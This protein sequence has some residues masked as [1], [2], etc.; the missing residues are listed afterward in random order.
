MEAVTLVTRALGRLEV[1]E[2]S[3]VGFGGAG[4]TAPLHPLERPFTDS[5]GPRILSQLRFDQVFDT[6]FSK[7]ELNYR[8]SLCVHNNTH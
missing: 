5:D 4:S 2:V 7:G 1:G 8:R 3:V 6:S